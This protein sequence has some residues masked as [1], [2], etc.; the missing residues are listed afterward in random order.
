MV[1]FPK[2]PSCGTPTRNA[3][4]QQIV[5]DGPLAKTARLYSTFCRHCGAVLGMVSDRQG[6]LGRGGAYAANAVL[7]Q[8]FGHRA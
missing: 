1:G 4:T 5:V 3:G 8:L 6:G 7:Q 2:C